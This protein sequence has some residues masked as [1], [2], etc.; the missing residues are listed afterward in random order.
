MAISFGALIVLMILSR[1][2][3]GQKL[4][5]TQMFA[6]PGVL[7]TACQKALNAELNC[8]EFL[9]TQADRYVK[10]KVLLRRLVMNAC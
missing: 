5:G 4:S 6:Q 3:S 2:T 9:A 7:S 8:T 1:Q 10:A